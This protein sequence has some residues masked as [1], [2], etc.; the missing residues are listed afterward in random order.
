MEEK[1]KEYYVAFLD[2]LG[3][4]EMVFDNDTKK[5]DKL[6]RLRNLLGLNQ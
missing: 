2:V 3:F 1:S 5:I 6:N 4:T